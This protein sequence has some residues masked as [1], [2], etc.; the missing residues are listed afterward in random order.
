MAVEYPTKLEAALLYDHV[1]TV[2]LDRVLARFN[3]AI[4]D[5]GV[6]FGAGASLG[7]GQTR[8]FN[9]GDFYFIISQNPEPLGPEGFR[10]ALSSSFVHMMMADAV[11]AVSEHRANLFIS[12]SLGLPMPNE[13]AASGPQMKSLLDMMT[14]PATTQDHKLFMLL[15]RF[16]MIMMRE[17]C[18]QDCPRAVHWIQ[19]DQLFIGEI[20]RKLCDDNGLL[21]LMY[22]PDINSGHDIHGQQVLSLTT[23]GARHLIGC[24]VDFQAAPM[25]L[26]TI[27]MLANAFIRMSFQGIIPDGDTFGTEDLRVKVH[28]GADRSLPGGG[29]VR[30]VLEYRKDPPYGKAWPQNQPP[31]GVEVVSHEG[32][33]PNLLDRLNL[34][35]ADLAGRSSASLVRAMRNRMNHADAP[36]TKA[37]SKTLFGLFRSALRARR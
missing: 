13:I 32:D 30:L 14:P 33:S 15:A 27:L 19:S 28:Y 2:D 3:A 16:L 1:T 11:A 37:A 18:N 5:S 4:A 34:E 7:G 9:Y 20:A 22:R 36:Q 10:G 29:L 24:E 21:N 8:I 31:A 6:A 12:F 35:T 17:I 25:D 23:R 26:E